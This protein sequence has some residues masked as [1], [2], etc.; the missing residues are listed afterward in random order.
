ML[1]VMQ[2]STVTRDVVVASCSLSDDDITK[3]MH[4]CL[5]HMGENGTIELSIRELLDGQKTSKL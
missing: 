2:G 3:L 5:G 4:M 1:Y